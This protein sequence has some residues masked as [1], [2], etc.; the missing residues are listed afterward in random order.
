MPQSHLAG[1]V[2]FGVA[3][4]FFL[5]CACVPLGAEASSGVVSAC[6]QRVSGVVRILPAGTTCHPGEYPVE[7][8]VTGPQGP[9]GDKGDAGAPGAPG[10][11]GPK[12]D[13]GG[14][15]GIATAVYGSVDKDGGWVFAS[16]QA[17]WLSSY[18]YMYSDYWLYVVE[19]PTFTDQTKVP[20]C[21]VSARP[22][23][24]GSAY[25]WQHVQVGVA[26]V[27]WSYAYNRWRFYVLSSQVDASGNWIPLKQAFDFICAQK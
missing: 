13:S 26:S 2:S 17:D 22:G 10:P 4:A 27:A 21:F 12:G 18:Q 3:V 11:Q 15:N 25:D 9:K 8:N 16:Q 23:Y 24:D 20:A 14:T 1:R 7:W 19:L 6:V 5:A